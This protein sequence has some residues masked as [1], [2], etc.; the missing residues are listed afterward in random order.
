[1][2]GEDTS[3]KKG[4]K[5]LPGGWTWERFKVVQARPISPKSQWG[6]F[7]GRTSVRYVS[8]NTTVLVWPLMGCKDTL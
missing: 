1:M 6:K 2:F 8:L 3:G 4:A 5:D 7:T